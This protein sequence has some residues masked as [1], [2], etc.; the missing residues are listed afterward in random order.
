MY[1]GDP[2]FPNAPPA[3]CCWNPLGTDDPQ[4]ELQVQSGLFFAIGLPQV[5]RHPPLWGGH[6]LFF[7]IIGSLQIAKS[8]SMPASWAWARVRTPPPACKLCW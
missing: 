6:R 7:S 5:G 4:T 3:C 1:A 8:V 2:E